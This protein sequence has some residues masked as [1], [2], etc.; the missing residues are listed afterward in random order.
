MTYQTGGELDQSH[1]QCCYILD[2]KRNRINVKAVAKPI[3][4]FQDNN[5]AVDDETP[6]L[7]YLP[8]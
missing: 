6:I 3:N 2:I 5:E 8:N 4:H 7:V 1:L